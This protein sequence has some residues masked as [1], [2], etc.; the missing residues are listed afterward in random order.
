MSSSRQFAVNVI[1]Q[2]LARVLSISANLVLLV[3]VARTMGT[4]M[5]GQFNYVLA[6]STIAVALADLGTTAVLARGLAQHDGEDRSA[7]LGNFLLMRIVI[8]LVVMAGAIGVAFALPNTLLAALLVAAVGLP[9]LA[10]RFFEPIYQVYGKPWLSLW[11]NLVFGVTQLMLAA[12]VWLLPAMDITALTVGVVA[13][14]LAYTVVAC[15]MMVALVKP[16]LRPR[17]GMMTG[18]LRVAAPV[19]VSSIFTSIILRSDVIILEHLRGSADVGLYSAAYK[20]LD[21]AVFVAITVVTPL[22]PIL[23]AEIVRDR[24]SALA[25]C[26][27]TAQFA[28]VCA[29]PVAIVLPSVGAPMLSAVFGP[30]FV[31]AV[32][33]LNVLVWNFVL[34]VFALLGSSI[35]LANGEIAHGYWNAPLACV[36]NLGLNFWLIPRMGIVGAAWA[37]VGSQLAMLL[38]SQFYTLTRFGNLYE[39]GVWARIAGACAALWLCLHFTQDAGPW[40]SAA[41]SLALYVG[42]VAWLGLFPRQIVETIREARASRRL[43]PSA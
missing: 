27:L 41:V 5:F 32:D 1:A 18:M 20:V 21:L 42:L 15:L 40:V 23:S 19:G 6:F 26:R 4:A 34:I 38:V 10:S 28:G 25:R 7:F 11:S 24:A 31:G 13:S 17:G 3:V 36:I 16:S 30:D 22:I 33:P 12:L 14:N 9:V 2:G 37:T 39:P 8:A 29:L 35:N 43:R